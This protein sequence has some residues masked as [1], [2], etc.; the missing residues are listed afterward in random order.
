MSSTCTCTFPYEDDAPIHKEGSMSLE[1]HL[2]TVPIAYLLDVG[3]DNGADILS[4]LC[5]GRGEV[6]V[7]TAPRA[8]HLSI[9]KV[10]HQEKCQCRASNWVTGG[11]GVCLGKA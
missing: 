6:V 4:A 5:V 8:S 10:N 9:L 2:A 1:G 11:S 7:S 3:D